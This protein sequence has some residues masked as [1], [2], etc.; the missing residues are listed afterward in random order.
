[1]IVDSLP[2]ILL[3]CKFCSLGNVRALSLP[4]VGVEAERSLDEL[5]VANEKLRVDIE[6]WSDA[7]DKELKDI[8]THWA[9]NHVDF[10]NKVGLLCRLVECVVG[11]DVLVGQ[12][13]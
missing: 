11:V 12:A 5:S 1:M 3:P 8:M 7:K 9:Q 10:H 2:L 6:K 13:K 4:Q